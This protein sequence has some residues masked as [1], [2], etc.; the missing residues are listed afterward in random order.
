MQMEACHAVGHKRWSKV[1][2]CLPALSLSSSE[3][4]PFFQRSPSEAGETRARE[5][6]HGWGP[7]FTVWICDWADKHRGGAWVASGLCVG[8]ACLTQC[9]GSW[10][11]GIT[12]WGVISCVREVAGPRGDPSLVLPPPAAWEV[13]LFLLAQSRCPW[14][15]HGRLQA[16]TTASLRPC[17]CSQW[18]SNRTRMGLNHMKPPAFSH[19]WPTK[20]A[21]THLPISP[22]A[23]LLHTAIRSRNSPAYKMSHW[24][25]SGLRIK[26]RL[27]ILASSEVLQDLA[28]ACPSPTSTLF[29]SSL[30]SW[31]W[32]PGGSWNSPQDLC[33]CPLHSASGS[34]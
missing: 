31:G 24:L 8:R 30:C 11:E 19:F 13:Q 28:P 33:I 16:G 1:V 26:S 21:G 4:V 17:S 10:S 12:G 9:P 5:E 6:G 20:T 3:E 15:S 25:L 27:F 23:L 32:P 2:V 34:F 18:Q 14:P 29:P 22:L 7:P